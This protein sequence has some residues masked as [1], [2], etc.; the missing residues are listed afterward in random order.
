M[1]ASLSI[2]G[3]FS[4][5]YRH[6]VLPESPGP[7]ILFQVA[8]SWP[9]ARADPFGQGGHALAEEHAQ[10]P[11]GGGEGGKQGLAREPADHLAATGLRLQHDSAG[12]VAAVVIAAVVAAN[13]AVGR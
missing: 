3:L 7:D 8:A 9:A 10:E 2:N 4:R 1:E 5:P 6:R 13:S 11:D 12:A